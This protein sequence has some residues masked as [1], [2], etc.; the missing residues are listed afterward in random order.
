[1][2]GRGRVPA[3]AAV[4]SLVGKHCILQVVVVVTTGWVGKGGNVDK[5]QGGAGGGGVG[6]GG[7]D[8]RRI[9]IL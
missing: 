6:W 9:S 2:T 5:C 8:A 4:M 7:R 3:A 1:M